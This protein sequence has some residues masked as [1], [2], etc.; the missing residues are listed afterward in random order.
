MLDCEMNTMLPLM[1]LCAKARNGF[2][3]IGAKA[4]MESKQ[5]DA[6]YQLAID[7]STPRGDAPRRRAHQRIPVRSNACCPGSLDSTF[8]VSHE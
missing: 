3:R 2:A 1:I 7:H 8:V 6:E 4:I 5:T